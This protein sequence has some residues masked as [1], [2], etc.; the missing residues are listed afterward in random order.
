MSV[1]TT[2]L[3]FLVFGS[4]DDTPLSTSK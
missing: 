3:V 1:Y 4:N 2:Y